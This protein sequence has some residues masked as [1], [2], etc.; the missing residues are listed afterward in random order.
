MPA[1]RDRISYLQS[2]WFNIMECIDYAFKF[3]NN[4]A[5]LKSED[6]TIHKV[7]IRRTYLSDNGT[8]LPKA[9]FI[10]KVNEVDLGNGLVDY[11]DA[12]DAIKTCID[13]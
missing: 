8:P 5:Y 13:P 9:R 3:A 1:K 12:Y 10:V 2:N 11:G 4:E 7:N 6:G